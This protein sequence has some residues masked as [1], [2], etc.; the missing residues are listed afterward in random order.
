VGGSSGRIFFAAFGYIAE[1]NF[2]LFPNPFHTIS[3]L[4]SSDFYAG[5]TLP[6][7]EILD[8]RPPE[9]WTLR[10]KAQFDLA[11]AQ[12]RADREAKAA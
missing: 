5:M 7:P 1:R 9:G 12:F 10:T 2:V 4:A 11:V 8:W 6:E 3:D